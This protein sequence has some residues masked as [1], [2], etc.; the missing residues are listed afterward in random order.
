MR[1]LRGLSPKTAENLVKA[2]IVAALLFFSDAGFNGYTDIEQRFFVLAMGIDKGTEEEP[3]EVTLKLSVPQ[4]SLSSNNENEYLLLSKRSRSIAGAVAFLKAKAG[5]EFDFG[6]MRII[7]IG[8][9]LAGEPWLKTLD[10]FFRR[11]D[12]QNVAYVA[13]AR[14][15]AKEVLRLHPDYERIPANAFLLSFGSEGTESPYIVSTYLFDMHRNLFER[16]VDPVVSIVEALG[17]NQY[18]IR[19]SYVVNESGGKLELNAVETGLF[20]IFLMRSERSTLVVDDGLGMP[21]AM[22]ADEIHLDYRFDMNPNRPAIVIRG[23]VY[24]QMEEASERVEPQRLADFE[25]RAERHINE[26]MIQL[27]V[28]LQRNGFDPFGFGLR[29]RA[30]HMDQESEWE[31]WRMIYPNVSFSSRIRVRLSGTGTIK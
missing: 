13:V 22:T 2:L 6:H 26:K 18:E 25:R 4:P 15:T 23:D 17:R 31:E 27:L 12:V 28:K 21:F 7:F 8:D 20:N 11:R 3:Y 24:A 14:P 19:D 5:K 9:G 10:W 30:A 16:G 1:F 29:Y